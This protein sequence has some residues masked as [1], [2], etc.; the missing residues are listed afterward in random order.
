VFVITT[1]SRWNVIFPSLVARRYS[2]YGLQRF[3]F[4]FLSFP[5]SFRMLISL[6][7]HFPLVFFPILLW[8]FT[9]LSLHFCLFRV[10]CNDLHKCFF[11]QILG[12]S[13]QGGWDEQ[14]M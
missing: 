5:L 10:Y 12:R 6:C 2:T 13:N 8:L 14:D 3:L 4:F 1:V 9:Y 7:F 11:R